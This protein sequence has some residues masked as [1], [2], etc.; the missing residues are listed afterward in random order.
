MSELNW[1]GISAINNLIINSPISIGFAD[2]AVCP[3]SVQQPA[4]PR[5]AYEK[6]VANQQ[7]C[8]RNGEVYK[9]K[10]HNMRHYSATQKRKTVHSEATRLTPG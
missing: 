6:L 7:N 2:L 4:Y 3:R 9:D 5:I 10:K 8:R 1:R